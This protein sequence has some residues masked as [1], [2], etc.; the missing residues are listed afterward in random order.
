MSQQRENMDEVR[1]VESVTNES[2]D[3]TEIVAK[4][5]HKLF[6][7]L[8]T[9]V[10]KFLDNLIDRHQLKEATDELNAQSKQYKTVPIS[11]LSLKEVE[12]CLRLEF[13]SKDT[14]MKDVQPLPLPPR[15]VSTLGL[16]ERTFGHSR[17]NE[18]SARWIVDSVIINAYETATSTI[19]NAQPLNVQCERGYKFGPVTL[20]RQKVVLSGRPDYS[21]W[22]GESESL[23]LNVLIVEAKGQIRGTNPIPQL[24]AYIGTYLAIYF[25]TEFAA[26]GRR[27]HL[28]QLLVWMLRRAAALSPSHSKETSVET[29]NEAGSEQMNIDI[30][31]NIDIAQKHIWIR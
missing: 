14:E 8:K 25:W 7:K 19:R 15:L 30:T 11:D 2:T 22:Y 1:S 16:I 27:T 12:K 9:K 20:N 5:N 26:A 21:V 29:D 10:L 31:G 28:E 6:H 3:A 17:I 13:D 23:C 24:L 18:A 4:Q